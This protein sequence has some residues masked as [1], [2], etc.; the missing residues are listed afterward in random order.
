M[1]QVHCDFLVCLPHRGLTEVGV[2]RIPAPPPGAPSTPTQG[3]RGKRAR[4]PRRKAGAG[5]RRTTSAT[6][7]CFLGPLPAGI[8]ALTGRQLGSSATPPR[9]LEGGEESVRG[10]LAH[11]PSLRPDPPD[12]SRTWESPAGRSGVEHRTAG[13]GRRSQ[14]AADASPA[15]THCSA[16]STVMRSIRAARRAGTYPAATQTARIVVATP[17]HAT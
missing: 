9:V 10:R 7:A 6:A 3:S 5:S 8:P 1:V 14:L 12:R 4:R 2:R 11:R 16:L 15:G 13:M 17:A